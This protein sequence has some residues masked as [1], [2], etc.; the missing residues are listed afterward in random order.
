[1][2]SLDSISP[3]HT[4]NHNHHQVI[5]VCLYAYMPHCVLWPLAMIQR[6]S[7]LLRI[8]DRTQRLLNKE[9]K[10]QAHH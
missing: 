7:L 9:P 3:H 10:A 8:A 2:P 4:I 1:M 6:A 5:N